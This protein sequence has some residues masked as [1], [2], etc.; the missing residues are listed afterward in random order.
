MTMAVVMLVAHTS[1]VAWDRLAATVCARATTFANPP[2][3]TFNGV[4]ALC[5]VSP[6]V[7]SSELG[8][9]CLFGV[10]IGNCLDGNDLTRVFIHSFIP[11]WET[12]TNNLQLNKLN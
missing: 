11:R 1:R 6:L 3:E 10:K 12:A 9:V 4:Y 2:T 8:V 5:L 7:K